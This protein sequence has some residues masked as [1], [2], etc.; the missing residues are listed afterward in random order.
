MQSLDR[1]RY[2]LLDEMRGIAALA[3]CFFHIGTRAGGLQLFPNGY[4][5][6]DFFFMLSGFV[7]AEAYETRLC[8]TLRFS[9]FLRLRL[10]RMA[11][12][13]VLGAVIGGTYLVARC[14]VA[15]EHSDSMS[16]T[17]LGNAFNLAILPKLWWGRATG[18]ELF[19]ANGPLW[20]L[21]FEIL[22]NLAWAAW[23]VRRSTTTI[24][25]FTLLGG[26]ILVPAAT[27]MGS[28]NLGWSMASLDGG[29]GR[30]CFGFGFGLLIQRCRRLI[31]AMSP[32]AAL[33]AT[34]ALLYA[35][36]LPI[37]RLPWTLFLVMAFLPAVLIIAVGAGK[38]TIIPGGTWLGLISYPLYGIH[39][40]L[41][42]IASGVAKQFNAGAALGAWGLLLVLPP[43]AAAWF[44]LVFWDTP[45]RARLLEWDGQAKAKPHHNA[46]Q[47]KVLQTPAI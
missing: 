12:V 24:A 16:E 4:L 36:A 3:V 21:F 47:V 46:H 42:A 20:S 6:V 13:A 23:L 15:P 27:R 28:L 43:V 44:T 38:H 25:A 18:W 2:A 10:I 34:L 35:L 14:L 40:P 5:A 41:L 26:L 33:V 31:P 29:L 45:L 11:P 17:L 9:T 32:F 19:P 22:I 37:P 8:S 39:E 1:G 30:V 7:L